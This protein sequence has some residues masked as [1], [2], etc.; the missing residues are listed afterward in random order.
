MRDKVREHYLLMMARI[1]QLVSSSSYAYSAFHMSMLLTAWGLWLLLPN[2]TF[3]AEVFGTMQSLASEFTWGA[4]AFTLGVAKMHL[5][6]VKK[7]ISLALLCLATGYIWILAGISFL[8]SVPSNTGGVVYIMLG[9]HEFW[10]YK[11]LNNRNP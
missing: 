2:G 1:S 6:I 9:L 11:R 8:F 10:L 3:D 7:S 4:V 5:I